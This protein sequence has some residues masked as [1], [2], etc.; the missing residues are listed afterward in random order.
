MVELGVGKNMVN[1]IRFWVTVMGVAIPKQRTRIFDLT[2]FGRR[3]LG[4]GG[5]DPYLEDLRTLW[6]LHWHMSSRAKEP[7]F[8]WH[9][10]FS[11]WSYP[12]LTRTDAL[13]AL[14]A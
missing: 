3:V 7:L 11:R 2:D 4:Q 12:E 5:Y 13:S 10:L 1:S 6:L 14:G 8:A 9:F